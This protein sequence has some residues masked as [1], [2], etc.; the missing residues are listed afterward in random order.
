MTVDKSQLLTIQ[1]NCVYVIESSNSTV[2]IV[3]S[4]NSPPIVRPNGS[5]VRR[6]TSPNFW[7][8]L[9]RVCVRV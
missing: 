6:V 8:A 7:T 9:L 2:R 1:C 3:H 5:R 4:T